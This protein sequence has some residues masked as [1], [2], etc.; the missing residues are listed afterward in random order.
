MPFQPFQKGQKPT[1]TKGQKPT[2][3]KSQPSVAM[4]PGDRKKQMRRMAMMKRMQAMKGG[5]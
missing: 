2:F 3:G 1:F 5:K 4:G